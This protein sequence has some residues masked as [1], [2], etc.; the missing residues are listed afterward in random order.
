MET[1]KM[2]RRLKITHKRS[3]TVDFDLLDENGECIA[4]LVVTPYA[5]RFIGDSNNIH[6]SEQEII[7]C[8]TT[9]KKVLNG[10][11]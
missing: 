6:L 7:F 3:D 4:E 10:L 2:N 9:A 1:E 8:I 5:I 11:L